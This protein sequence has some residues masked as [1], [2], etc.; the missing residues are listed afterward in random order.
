MARKRY[1][2]EDCLKIL[3]QVAVEL[4]GGADVATA[5]LRRRP[6]FAKCFRRQE[7]ESRKGK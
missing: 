6:Q 4:A 3:R 5:Y 1:S 7:I 2:D